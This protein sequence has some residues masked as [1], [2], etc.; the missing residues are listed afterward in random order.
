MVLERLLYIDERILK[1]NIGIFIRI[2]SVYSNM[3]GSSYIPY[4]IIGFLVFWAFTVVVGVAV[5]LCLYALWIRGIA[6]VRERIWLDKNPSKGESPDGWRQPVA[7][8]VHI[9]W[10]VSNFRIP[11]CW[12]WKTYKSKYI[13][14]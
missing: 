12:R 9:I 14:E 3:L 6:R 7:F 4:E 13:D 10:S 1:H 8:F 11:I 5:L 2:Q